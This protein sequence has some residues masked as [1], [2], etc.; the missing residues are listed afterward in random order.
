MKSVLILLLLL[1]TGSYGSDKAVIDGIV[2]NILKPRHIGE[3]TVT[4]SPF[5]NGDRPASKTVSSAKKTTPKVELQGIVNKKAL[6]NGRLYQVGDRVEGYQLQT[7]TEEGI[8]LLKNG[9]LYAAKLAAN[10]SEIQ[11]KRDK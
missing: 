7:I 11:I 2:S 6:I 10:G 5:V 8:T 9:I 1:L 4:K 3:I